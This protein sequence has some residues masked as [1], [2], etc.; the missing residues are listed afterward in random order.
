MKKIKG[1]IK[2][3]YQTP[4]HLTGDDY[5]S[6]QN[7]I[8]LECIC[9]TSMMR[10]SQGAFIA[11]FA[12]ML[13]MSQGL[14]GIIS[15][16]PML[17]NVI[18]LIGGMY[19]KN[20]TQYKLPITFMSFI[21]RSMIGTI[22][23]I[24]LLFVKSTHQAI[25]LILI[26]AI[27]NFG[28]A[29]LN[30]GIVNWIMDLVPQSIRGEF[31]ARREMF[32]MIIAAIGELVL[33]QM[34]DIF[35]FRGVERLGFSI[36]STIVMIWAFMSIYNLSKIK[37]PIR[38]KKTKKLKAKQELGRLFMDKNFKKLGI[39]YAIWN[40]ALYTGMLYIAIYMISNL[41]MS[42]LYAMIMSMLTLGFR[43]LSVRL[44]G[45]FVE[46]HMWSRAIEIG[47]I[48]L[49]LSTGMLFFANSTTALFILPISH[50]LSGI[51]WGSIGITFFNLQVMFA[52]DEERTLYIGTLASISGVFGFIA[53]LGS[54]FFIDN[55]SNIHINIFNFPVSNIQIVFLV[56]GTLLA[57]CGVYV[58]NI[59]APMEQKRLTISNN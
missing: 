24:P 42:Y 19:F 53:T 22:Y 41:Q 11:G 14:I 7:F 5:K 38:P 3:V 54:G 34:L 1:W 36:L 51:A 55:F 32:T 44:W 52:P 28:I 47:A 37:E 12:K 49:G 16:I 33:A 56:S 29:F 25:A 40:F 39:L 6:G 26:Y 48:L 31:F 58:R 4:V 2:D 18:Q 17:A 21:I 8:I 50:I 59:I 43:V 9:G 13:G 27:A 57:L 10:L 46:A 20:M 45:K 30:P 23:F 15:A 35:K